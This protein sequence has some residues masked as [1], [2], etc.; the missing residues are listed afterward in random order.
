MPASEACLECNR[1][2]YTKFANDNID[3]DKIANFLEEVEEE[4]V[5]AP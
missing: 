1:K 4:I 5:K 2:R 3:K